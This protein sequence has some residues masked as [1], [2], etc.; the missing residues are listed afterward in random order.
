MTIKNIVR[1][2]VILLVLMTSVLVKAQEINSYDNVIRLSG[3]GKINNAWDISLV[4]DLIPR[5]GY[6]KSGCISKY[7]DQIIGSYQYNNQ[8]QS[9]HLVGEQIKWTSERLEID[10]L[11]VF[12]LNNKYERTGQ[13]IG[14][15]NKNEFTGF[16]KNLNTNKSYPFSIKF[17]S[18]I[19]GNLTVS[20]N[21]K[22]IDLIDIKGIANQ[23]TYNLIKQIDKKD[24]L[25]IVLE[26]IEPSCG[27]YNCRGANCGGTEEYVYLY[28]LTNNSVKYFKEKISSTSNWEEIVERI[29]GPDKYS[30]VTENGYAQQFLVTIDYNNLGRGIIKKKR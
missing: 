25:V 20:W 10:S 24:S 29:P 5:T 23:S 11:I 16:W 8:D 2:Y 9:I 17:K 12:E 4:I 30:L 6:N 19:F 22:Q 26:T 7:Y 15:L 27:Y 3:I 28:L 1:T 13:F 21:G 14:R 18:N